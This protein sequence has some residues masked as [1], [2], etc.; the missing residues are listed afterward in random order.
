M[1]VVEIISL[2]ISLLGFN[3]LIHVKHLLQSLIPMSAQLWLIIIFLGYMHRM[4]EYSV[5]IF[6]C[7]YLV[8]ERNRKRYVLTFDLLALL[9]CPFILFSLKKWL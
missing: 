7:S 2:P 4:C 1:Y 6:Q 5:H 9:N 3:K 8:S